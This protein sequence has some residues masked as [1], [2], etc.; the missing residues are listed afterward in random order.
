MR[1]ISKPKTLRTYHSVDWEIGLG[2]VWNAGAKAK[3]KRASK[4]KGEK[5]GRATYEKRARRERDCALSQMFSNDLEFEGR[6]EPTNE[7]P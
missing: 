3:A 5:Q 6:P 2:G 4:T 7:V 1:F